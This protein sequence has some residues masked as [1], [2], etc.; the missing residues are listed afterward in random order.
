MRRIPL[1]S[2]LS[3]VLAGFVSV[4]GATAAMAQ[5]AYGPGVTDVEIKI[6]NTNP[7]SGPASA[8][9]LV[10]R[11]EQAYFKMVNEAGG[12]NGRK[13]NFISYDDAYSPP[14]T[15][16]QT[17]KL[18]ESDEVF[19]I[20]SSVGTPTS[21]AVQKYLNI[22]KVPQLFV[23][24]GAGNFN[25]PKQFPWSM[26]HQ[27]NYSAEGRIL[28]T[29][30]MKAQPKAKIGVLYQNDDLG[31]DLLRGLLDGLGENQELVVAQEPYQLSDPSVDTQVLK[32]YAAKPDVFVNFASPKA[33]AQAI[34][35]IGELNWK[36]I[37][38][39]GKVAASVDAV[40]KPA[41]LDHAEGI[42]SVAFAKEYSDPQWADD[43]ARN[44]YGA[45]MDKFMPGVEK[46][47][48]LAVQAYTTSQHLVGLLELCG[49]NLTREN[50]MKQAS[51]L[52]GKL[53]SGMLLPG[54]G[55]HTTPD[56]LAPLKQLQLMRL[57]GGNWK[58]FGDVLMAR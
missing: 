24:S 7:Y 23:L 15:V 29:Y 54:I 50:L 44:V 14:K 51:H 58:L 47:N 27:V 48:T 38:F 42:V 8:Y 19:A 52:D 45:F 1:K 32:I 18:V 2:V 53:R 10:G 22:K 43:P 37:Q 41:G 36:P 30:I 39:V 6:G 9:G 25:M 55:L 56:D 26:S 35:K 40:M 5:K 12:V 31:K 57:E 21:L 28:A 49:D 20:V 13:I 4:A 11:V 33:A 46:N 34:R 16:E 17:R 3:I